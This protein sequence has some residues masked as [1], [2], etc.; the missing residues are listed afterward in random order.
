MHSYV[1]W[2]LKKTL[3]CVMN[4]YAFIVSD[5]SFV[6][7]LF[8]IAFIFHKKSM[9]KLKNMFCLLPKKKKRIFIALLAHWKAFFNYINN[10]KIELIFM[11]HHN[12][13]NFFRLESPGFVW[14]YLKCTHA[15]E[16]N[17]RLHCHSSS[18][19]KTLK[20]M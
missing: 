19:Y 11:F 7:L 20:K 16:R 18:A 2:V 1:W 17:T 5:N 3:S 8:Y 15:L 12:F 13:K 14:A 9:L 6:V 4:Y 10:Q